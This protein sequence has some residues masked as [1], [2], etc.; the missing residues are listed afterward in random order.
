MEIQTRAMQFEASVFI[1]EEQFDEGYN[2]F[3]PTDTQ[4]NANI[5]WASRSY[6]GRKECTTKFNLSALIFLLTV[7]RA[8]SASQQS[9]D[10]RKESIMAGR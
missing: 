9:F 8:G 7:L 2:A 3:D 5:Y 4:I 1:T 6:H 10:S